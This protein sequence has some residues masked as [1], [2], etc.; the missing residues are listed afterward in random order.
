MFQF[1]AVTLQNTEGGENP[2]TGL[3]YI[4]SCLE[5]WLKE[6]LKKDF[7]SLQDQT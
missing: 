1:K 2:C 4:N 3:N 6:K 7:L 5:F